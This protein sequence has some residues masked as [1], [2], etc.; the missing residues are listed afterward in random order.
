V[1]ALAARAAEAGNRNAAS[2]A[3]VGALLAGAAARGAAYNVRINVVSLPDRAP[4]EPLAAE[5]A[6]LLEQVERDVARARAAVEAA[7][8][9]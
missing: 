8:G 3:G 6:R 2:D 4:G 1:A 7:I 9:G 5:A